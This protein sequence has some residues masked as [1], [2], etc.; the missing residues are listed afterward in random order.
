M[1][2]DI[3]IGQFYPGS[4]LLHSL[5]ARVKLLGV[6]VYS[7]GIFLLNNIFGFI[8][9]TA[10]LAALIAISDVPL[11]YM[12][13]GLRFV[14]VLIAFAVII[15]LF[16]TDGEHV[17]WSWRFLVISDTGILKAAFFAIRLLYVIVGASLLTY[18][19]TPTD[20]TAGMEK[21]LRPL[22]KI[23]V[24]VQEIAM[25]MSIALRFIPILAEEVNKIIDAQLARGAEFDSGG[26]IKKA[27]G[28]VPILV[29]LFVSAFRRASDLATAMEARCYQGGPGRTKMN[30]LKY[31]NRDKA[32][33]FVILAYLLGIIAIKVTLNKLGV[34]G[35]V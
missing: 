16:F 27:K 20:L 19:T 18:T 17:F 26:L 13:R 31:E 21:A 11:R 23:H 28:M 32:A 30:P 24:P 1:F 10:V 2:R 35:S 15:N 4:S 25:M 33:Y 22:N 29:P 34:W 12:L 6:I 14:V 8:F 9:I 7:V 5:D 3:T